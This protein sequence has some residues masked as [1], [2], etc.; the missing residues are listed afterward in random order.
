MDIKRIKKIS[1]GDDAPSI[2]TKRTKSEKVV[3]AIA[4][5]IMFIYAISLLYPL[6]YLT[7]NS[8]QDAL[9][10]TDN[11]I[12]GENPFAFPS[13]WHPENYITAMQGMYMTDSWG[14]KVYLPEM[15]FNSLWYCGIALLA[16][17]FS[18][19][20]TAYILSK[21]RFKGR[22]F[23]YGLFIVVMT[24]PITG[25]GGADFKL[26]SDL[27]LYNNPLYVLI[28]NLGGYGFNFLVM[29]GVFTNVSWSY[30]EA[31]FIDGGGHF[32]AFF[33]VMLPQVISPIIMLGVLGFIG[34]WNNYTTPLLYLPDFPTVSSGLYR[35]QKSFLRDGDKPAYY[36]GLMLATIP[37]IVLYMCF[38]E[39]I[40]KNMA[41]GGLK[42]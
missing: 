13:T 32:T 37:L 11:L 10:Y 12:K 21:Y 35:I 31:V 8:F 15:F 19:S 14:E 36:A 30:A 34:Q 38:S 7:I 17:V 39:K 22:N 16:G 28:T 4:F 41:I 25:T 26:F 33:K 27:G 42:G 20:C 5:V 29:Y 1:K 9:V 2:L 3:Y 18:C 6:F 40:T 23:I 24:L